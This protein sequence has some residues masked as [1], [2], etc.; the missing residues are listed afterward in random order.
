MLKGFICP[1]INGNLLFSEC[2]SNPPCEKRC[3][4]LPIL[5]T[6]GDGVRGVRQGVYS[7]TE[8]LNPPRVVVYQRRFDYYL[9]PQQMVW[10]SFGTSFHSMVED[11]Q[12]HLEVIGE[13]ENYT[14][15]SENKFEVDIFGAKLTGIPDQYHVP[16]ET[17]T[18][19][20]TLKYYYDLYYIM[21]K[22]D[23]SQSKYAWQVNIY[24]RFRFPN[25]K[26]QELVCLVKDFNRKLRSTKD[27]KPIETIEVPIFDDRLVDLEVESRISSILSA[28]EDDDGIRD[29]TSDEIWNGI[30]CREYCPT[31]EHCSQYWQLKQGEW[32]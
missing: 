3:L 7:T 30:R 4:P 11:A 12:E 23:W 18:D 15:E 9:D 2:Y 8:I 29:C 16:S 10:A 14:F 17:I 32:K 1:H 27:V 21:E 13:R 22:K 5:I 19:Y 25:C 31:N 6:L 26:R 28:E 20:K 24:R